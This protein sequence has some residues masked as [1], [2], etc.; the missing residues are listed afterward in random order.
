MGK[1]AKADKA[2]GCSVLSE[3]STMRA[4]SGRARLLLLTQ[5]ALWY[6]ITYHFFVSAEKYAYGGYILE[7]GVYPIKLQE[8]IPFL[9]Y[10]RNYSKFRHI[11][12]HT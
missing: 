9:V 7:P 5:G 3:Q 1:E 11:T 4:N 6:V 12:Q 8:Y 2:E 10:S